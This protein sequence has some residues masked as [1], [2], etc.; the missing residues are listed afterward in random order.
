M[1][2]GLTPDAALVFLCPRRSESN[3]IWVD[4]G[5]D[6]WFLR[7]SRLVCSYCGSLHPELFM[8]AARLG[9]ELGP[10]DKNYKIYVGSDHAKFFFQHLGQEQQREFV[11]LMNS[12]VLNLGPTGRFYVDPYFVSRRQP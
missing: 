4:S 1:S 6:E 11:E 7:A 10:T 12:G 2:T 5:P 8:D 9:V 3:G